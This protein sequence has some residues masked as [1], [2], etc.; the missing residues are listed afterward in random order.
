MPKSEDISFAS[1]DSINSRPKKEPI[2]VETV[3]KYSTFF[4]ITVLI[5]CL[6]GFFSFRQ[7][8][9]EKGYYVFSWMSSKWFV[10]GFT[11]ISVWDFLKLD[12]QV[13]LLS[14]Y[15]EANQQDCE[16]SKWGRGKG[17]KNRCDAQVELRHNI[18]CIVDNYLLLFVQRIALVPL[19]S[20][21]QRF[22]FPNLQLVSK[23][24]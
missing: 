21:R 24:A 6:P 11:V 20:W 16:S 4:L 5:F 22:M 12:Y 3:F 17:E 8:C 9:V 15:E 13:F 14:W 10:L 23:L 1:T 19:V 18:L 2:K 7:Y